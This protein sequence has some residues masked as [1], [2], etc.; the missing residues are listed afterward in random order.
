MIIQASFHSAFIIL[1]TSKNMTLCIIRMLSFGMLLSYL[2]A[3][4][5]CVCVFLCPTL[6][7]RSD[8]VFFFQ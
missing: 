7:Q 6:C 3:Y 5:V 4:Y 2:R 8:S 1:Y